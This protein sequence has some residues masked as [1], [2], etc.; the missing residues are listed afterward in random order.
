MALELGTQNDDTLFGDDDV[1]FNALFGLGGDDTLIGGNNSFNYLYGDF[2]Q[3]AVALSTFTGG[4]DILTGGDSSTNSLYGDFE[5]FIGYESTL[6]GGNDILTG[7]DTSF[8]Y[9][10]GDSQFL[11]LENST[12]TGGD[13]ILTGGDNG[14]NYL[15]G[16]VQLAE[17]ED[18]GTFTGGNDILISGTGTDHMWGDGGVVGDAT[19]GSD[20]FVFLADNG[21]DI[22]HDF[23]QG[24]DL[25]DI[26]A[27][28]Q[29][30]LPAGLSKVIDKLPEQAVEAILSAK[31]DIEVVGDDS[32]IDFGDGNSVTVLGVADLTSSDFLLA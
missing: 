9:L 8:N 19:G 26:S 24:E 7:G 22:I 11:S 12:F 10:Y 30:L 15:Y 17:V 21:E 3:D 32:V 18:G 1:D 5:D 14:T 2:G 16:D 29:T 13:D 25:I 31:L 27:L 4:D 23:E 28:L 20:V 6:T